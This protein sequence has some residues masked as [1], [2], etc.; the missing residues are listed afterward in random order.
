MGDNANETESESDNQN[1]STSRTNRVR[2]L[3]QLG[4]TLA[5]ALGAGA[6]ASAARANAGQCCRNC[7][8]CGPCVKSGWTSPCYCFCD[9]TGI[10]SSYCLFS[11][12]GCRGFGE[13]CIACG[14]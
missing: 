3:K 8:Q 9:C 13:G 10:G 2:F 4:V 12:T 14:C 6:F 7:P 5:A 11:G 1:E